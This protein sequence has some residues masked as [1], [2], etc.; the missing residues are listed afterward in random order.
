M[1]TNCGVAILLILIAFTVTTFAA[2]PEI[3]QTNYTPSPAIPGTTITL[4]LQV[5]NKDSII[6]SNVIVNV[7]STYP[8]TVKTSTDQSNPRNIGDLGAY[9]KTQVPY[10]IYID[11]SA[12]NQTYE[13]PVTVSTKLDTTG[14]K[15]MVPIIVGGKEPIVKVLSTSNDKLLPGEEKEITLTLQNV[16][17][18]Q[19]YDIVVEMQEDRTVTATGTVV[20]R[21]IT[22]LGAAAAYLPSISPGEEKS[23]NLR[24]SV[25]TSATIKN[26]TQPVKVSYRDAAGTR[27]TDTSY[28]G[29]KVFGNADLDATLKDTTGTTIAGQSTD[30]TIE[31]F[32]KGL[33]KAEFVI[34]EL[35]SPEGTIQKPKQF[36]G[37]LGP[38]DVDTVKT[39]I[40]FNKAGDNTIRA[41][42]SYQDADSTMKK[43]N[44]NVT[45]KTETTTQGI[46]PIITLIVIVVIIV[47]AWNFLIK[48]K[49]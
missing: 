15:T 42:I 11:P 45:I 3:T 1:K 24:V 2:T 38:N 30:V 46:N 29:L 13:I 28:I 9:G 32:N 36:I 14:K 39:P 33:G 20:E 35:S 17:T 18:S 27:T 40:T 8:F 19:A 12:E 21:D 34:V 22:P 48:K 10:T 25:S 4:L 41:T 26:Y 6:Q 23:V 5:E 44:I 31:I 49:K 47:L 7:D 16:G 37:S 43:V